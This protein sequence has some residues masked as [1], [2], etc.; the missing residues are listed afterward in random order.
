MDRGLISFNPGAL[1]LHFS[2]DEGMCKPRV[3]GGDLLQTKGK[4]WFRTSH[5]IA[6]HSP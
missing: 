2:G 3:C 6:A 1:G 4:K 5:F